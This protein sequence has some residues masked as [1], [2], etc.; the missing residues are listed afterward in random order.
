MIMQSNLC[1]QRKDRGRGEELDENWLPKS[2]DGWMSRRSDGGCRSQ[3]SVIFASCEQKVCC[4]LM[5]MWIHRSSSSLV[6]P[7]GNIFPPTAFPNRFSGPFFLPSDLKHS[8]RIEESLLASYAEKR[9]G[10]ISESRLQ[11]NA[12]ACCGVA[13]LSFILRNS[14]TK[15][16][17]GVLSKLHHFLKSL[18]LRW[19]RRMHPMQKVND[20]WEEVVTVVLLLHRVLSPVHLLLDFT[21]L[22]SSFPFSHHWLLFRSIR[23]A[24][25]SLLHW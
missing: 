12:E 16:P 10:R 5:C 17:S 7:R 19:V 25:I 6:S 21:T 3:S 13:V 23:P 11:K 15:Y 14:W 1:R 20:G 8:E 4:S 18:L 2:D 24:F 9:V 22:I